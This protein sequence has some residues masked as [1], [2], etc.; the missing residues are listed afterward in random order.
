VKEV[1]MI[2]WE[3]WLTRDIVSDNPLPWQKRIDKLTPGRVAQA[4]GR[5]LA[6][7]VTPTSAPIFNF[8]FN[9]KLKSKT[10]L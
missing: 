10:W 4:M 9:I 5:V 2:T 1:P 3:L 8:L 7:I 6:A